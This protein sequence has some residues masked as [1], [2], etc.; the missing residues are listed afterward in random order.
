MARDGI[1]FVLGARGAPFARALPGTG[2]LTERV[3][4]EAERFGVDPALALDATQEIL[5]RLP[6]A[7]R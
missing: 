5:A 4:A 3:R 2:D 7:G 6:G 1:G